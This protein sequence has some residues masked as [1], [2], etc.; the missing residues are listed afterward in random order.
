[1]RGRQIILALFILLLVT[2]GCG[3]RKYSAGHPTL[4]KA[5]PEFTLHDLS[6]RTWRL[7]DLK[8][9]VVMINF[10]ATWC[11]PC[12]GELD[13]MQRLYRRPEKNFQMLTVLV[14]DSPANG[15]EL[16]RRKK[17]TFPV[18]LDPEGNV[19][20]DYGITGVPET[21]II[22]TE[23]ILRERIIG[24]DNWDSPRARA[25]IRARLN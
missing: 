18:L 25:M 13:S 1:M 24:G 11:P 19:G 4:G 3:D 17:Y 12:R 20:R 5:V 6:G 21:F 9:K 15:A 23:G 14:N 7:A 8:G 22:D 10:W 16:V 2:S